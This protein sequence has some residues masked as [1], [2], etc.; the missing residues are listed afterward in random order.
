MTIVGKPSPACFVASSFH[1]C[2]RVATVAIALFLLGHPSAQAQNAQTQGGVFQHKWSSPIPP[3]AITT[4]DV[5][6]ALVW[7]RH[8]GA[9]VD[10]DAGPYLRR[11]ISGWQ[12]SKGFQATGTLTAS[13]KMDL[14]REGLKARDTHGWAL[15]ID[16]AIGFSVGIP[17]K[18]STPQPPTRSQG[19]WWY[20]ASGAF[21]HTV[22]VIPRK[23]ACASMDEMFNALLSIS[24]PDREVTYQAR[25]DDWF[26]IAG[27]RG[28]HR[29]YTR[30]QCRD[31]AI[32]RVIMSVHASQAEALGF[33]FVAV[34]NSLSLKPTLNAQAQP[35]PRIVFPPPPPG[36]AAAAT[37]PYPSPP[38]TPQ[39]PEPEPATSRAPTGAVDKAGKTASIRLTLFDGI[40]LK[41]REVFERASETVYVVRTGQKQGSAVA[42]SDREV[43][44]NCHVLD[45]NLRAVLER[46]GR[47]Q[48]A[49]LTS[50]N[51]KADRC[52]LTSEAPLP[53]WVRVRPYAD[54]KVGE[55]AFSIGAPQGLELTIA[56][57]I[58]SAKRVIDGE[59]LLQTSAPISRGSSGGG[60]FDA[61]GQ[62]IGITTWMRKDAQNLNFAIAA[63]EFA[64]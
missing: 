31:Q 39:I 52:I 21:G 63:E 22:T 57:G 62:L 45:S 36:Y 33:M 20:E 16:D 3:D 25:K 26:V 24:A 5:E 38:L 41:P 8:L 10:G 32:V 2:F 43:V 27:R 13:Q 29:F 44:T 7:T 15:M 17:T 37:R 58:V 50:A 34:A 61:Q 14:V 55:R 11:A 6:N 64:R 60:L 46:D 56:E 48:N 40:E 42:I 59:R 19:D 54:I 23:A 9:A 53:K 28:E 18:F 12:T 4:T 49:T 47:K 35:S 51:P 30:A 1:R